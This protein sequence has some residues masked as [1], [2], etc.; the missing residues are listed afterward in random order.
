MDRKYKI[1][2]LNLLFAGEIQLIDFREIIKYNLD[3][4]FLI[5]LSS[6]GT[7]YKKIPENID[8]LQS[9]YTKIGVTPK[10][11]EFQNAS[12]KADSLDKEYQEYLIKN[13]SRG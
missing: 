5:H 1:K 3:K 4:P 10:I 9:L 11:I 12:A 8:E 7:I 2:L 13:S 6:N